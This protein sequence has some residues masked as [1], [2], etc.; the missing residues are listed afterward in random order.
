MKR[1]KIVCTIGPA[2]E[3]K[4]KIE[5][6]I[7]SGLNVARLNFSHGTYKHHTMLI[8]NIRAVSAK[9]NEPVA[10]LQDLQG[11]RIRIGGVAKEGI[12]VE[13][14]EE[15]VLVPENFKIELKK[16]STFIPIQ[17]PDL[18]KDVKPK[19]PILID[20]AKIELEVIEIKNKAIRCRVRI[21]DVIN[22]HKGM[23][24]PKTEIRTPAVT[25]KDRQDLAFGLGQGI[26]FVAL[27]FVKNAKDIIDLRRT[28]HQL[29]SRLGQKQKDFKKPKRS[30]NWPGTHTKIIAKIERPEAV[31]NFEEILAA[32]DGIM[33]ARGDLGL[34]I[35][36]E[37]LPL[38]QKKIVRRCVEESKPVIVATQMLDSMIRYPVPTRAE[39]SDVANAILDGTDAIMLSGETATGKYPLKAV[40]VMSRIAHQVEK[41]EIAEY[42]E[43]Q[44]SL[45]KLGGITETVS[46]AVQTIADDVNAK[47]IICATTSGF[48]ARSISKYRPQISVAALAASE[49]T[50]NQLCLSWGVKPYYLKFGSSFSE[51]VGQ[52]RKL[53]QNKRLVKKGGVVV[54]AAGHPFGYL[55][56]TNLIKV[57]TI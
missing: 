24:F 18:Y 1:T 27:S 56:Q 4:T 6:M 12:K 42:K 38:I 13:A 54:I 28:I 34:E 55:G 49:K 20:D 14:G 25:K 44:D 37:D 50:K 23:N 35:P 32:A 22:S 39:V 5:Q 53:C 10:I 47:L 17:Y 29:E 9:L 48:T 3:S 7:K 40:Q 11:P 15:I 46:Y 8:K 51:L 2:S 57:E 19:D 36:L 43:I 52:A 21:G 26:D 31:K 33:V 41:T 45:K 16:I 30:G